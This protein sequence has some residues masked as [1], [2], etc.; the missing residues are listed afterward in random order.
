[1]AMLITLFLVLINIFNIVTTNSPN[2]EGM[3]AIAAWM[4]VCI[5]FVFGALGMTSQIDIKSINS[6]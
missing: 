6:N 3:T 4:L 1:M 2:V 5:F